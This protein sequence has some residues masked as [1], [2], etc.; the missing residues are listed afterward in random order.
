LGAIYA[1]LIRRLQDGDI[2]KDLT[3]FDEAIEILGEL[4]E[5][6]ESIAS[7]QADQA[8]NDIIPAVPVRMD[9]RVAA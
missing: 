4:N 6:W 7:V 3:A 8:N 9:A 2:N 5:A 1:Y